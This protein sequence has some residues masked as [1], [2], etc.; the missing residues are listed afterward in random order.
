M[1]KKKKKKRKE[2]KIVIVLP[3][4]NP[5]KSIERDRKRNPIPRE[6]LKARFGAEIFVTYLC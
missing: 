3:Q 2:R 1:E 4:C 5:Q 6:P